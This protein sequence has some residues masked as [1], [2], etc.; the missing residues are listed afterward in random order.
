MK[1]PGGKEPGGLEVSFKDHCRNEEDRYMILGIS[2]IAWK[3]SLLRKDSD[4]E[5]I[6]TDLE[7]TNIVIELVGKKD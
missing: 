3:I 5:I 7:I 1:I 2:G 6:C 4:A